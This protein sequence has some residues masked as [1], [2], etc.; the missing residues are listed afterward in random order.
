[1]FFTHSPSGKLVIYCLNN[2]YSEKK[3]VNKYMIKA[4]KRGTRTRYELFSKLASKKTL[5]RCHRRC[6]DVFTTSFEHISHLFFV[7]IL[8]TL[9]S[10]ELYIKLGKKL[11]LLHF[12]FEKFPIFNYIEDKVLTGTNY[13][14]LRKWVA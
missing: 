11:L 8:L 7:L 10:V 2:T 5:E 9:K 3:S 6:S 4:K 1:M 14:L 12:R 13:R